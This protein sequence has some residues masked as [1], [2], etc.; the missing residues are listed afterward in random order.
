[1]CS[2]GTRRL[3]LCRI[4]ATVMVCVLICGTVMIGGGA[5]AFLNI[6]A[7]MM[8]CGMTF[9]L[10]LGV[11]GRDFLKF[12]PD[13]ILSL[14]STSATPNPRFADIAKSGRRFVIGAGILGFMI[15][16][17]QM[18]RTLADPSR[19]GPG[20]GVGLLMIAYAVLASEIFFAFLYSVYS[21]HDDRS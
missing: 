13:A 3:S 1:M 16:L 21:T 7:L 20:I 10:L 12:I 14:F 8:T 18:L 9:F 17:I 19:M 5:I 6:R 4:V 11:Y 2:S 15:E